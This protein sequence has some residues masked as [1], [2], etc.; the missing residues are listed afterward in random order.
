MDI[1]GAQF[2]GFLEQ[3]VDGAHN[4]RAAGKIA[5]AVDVVVADGRLCAFVAG[6]RGGVA[7]AEAFRQRGFDVIKRTN[8]EHDIVA[9][10]DLGRSNRCRVARIGNGDDVSAIGRAIRKDN[11]LAQEPA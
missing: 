11:H 2:D 8:L 7:L 9:E 5:K 10:H 3:V 1:A 4:R 6:K